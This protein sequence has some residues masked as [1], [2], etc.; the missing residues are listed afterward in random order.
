MPGN[1]GLLKSSHSQYLVIAN[2]SVRPSLLV[3]G[4]ES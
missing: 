2:S 4:D 1:V 3:S